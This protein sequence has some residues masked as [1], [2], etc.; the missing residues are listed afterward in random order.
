MC[1]VCGFDYINY[2]YILSLFWDK[3]KNKKMLKKING[4]SAKLSY[5]SCDL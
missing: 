1:V 5:I 4:S 2:I 3:T